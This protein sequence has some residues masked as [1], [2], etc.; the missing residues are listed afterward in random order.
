[1]NNIG[2]LRASQV[3]AIS[4]QGLGNLLLAAPAINAVAHALGGP[5]DLA[6]RTPTAVR[7]VRQTGLAANTLLLP[8]GRAGLPRLAAQ[9]RAGRYR[10][11]LVCFPGGRAAQL[12]ARLSGATV[13]IGHELPGGMGSLARLLT[14]RIAHDPLAHDVERNMQLAEALLGATPRRLPGPAIKLPDSALERADD[15]IRESGLQS[16]GLVGIHPGSDP[17]FA[18]KRWPAR[19]FARLAEL[20]HEHLGWNTI[21]LDGPD[22]TVIEA[23]I[24]DLAQVPMQ[25]L[26]GALD[27][28]DTAALIARCRA[29]V[30]NDSGIMHLACAVGAP[31]LALFG[32][33]QSTRAAPWSERAASVVSDLE[34]APCHSLQGRA[35]CPQGYPLCMERIEPEVVLQR[36]V[37]LI[38]N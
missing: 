15:F 31:C 34:C 19:H 23:Q 33:S 13:R 11:A 20:I 1:M 36:L 29:V 28:L 30:S 37:E 35:D 32:P 6:L 26:D 25:S 21:V 17:G 7:F 8:P 38:G 14:V 5:L 16:A 2:Q 3:L 10:A 22:E 27:V 24:R 18:D 9:C 4:L 12:L